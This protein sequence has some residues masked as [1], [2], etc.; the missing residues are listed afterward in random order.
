MN[1]VYWTPG[2]RL[3]LQ[4][5]QQYIS[6]QHAGEAAEK[7]VATLLKRTRQLEVAPL[8]GRK[9]PGYAD[10]DIRQLLEKPYR[11]IYRIKAQNIEILTVMHYRQLLTKTLGSLRLVDKSR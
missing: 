11:I 9:I 5:I 8:S 2:A 4:E 6:D 7:I 10:D 3:R 1:Q